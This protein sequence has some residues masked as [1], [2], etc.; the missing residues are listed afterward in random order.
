MEYGLQLAAVAVTIAL[1]WI[2]L[3]G[4]KRL[5]S[6]GQ[7]RAGLRIAQRIPLA[8]GCQLVAVHWDGQDLL[9][10]TGA[11]PCTL[12]ASRPSAAP[13]PPVVSGTREAASAWAG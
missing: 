12:I 2:T 6:R 8:N 1:L 11:Q 9:I 13:P 4:L 7:P 10:A 3:Q 5:Q